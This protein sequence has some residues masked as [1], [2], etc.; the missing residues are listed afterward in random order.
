MIAYPQRISDI[1]PE[2]EK[3]ILKKDKTIKPF[4][5]RS[6]W[7]KKR[8]YTLLLVENY[9]EV[10]LIL[11]RIISTLTRLGAIQDKISSSPTTGQTLRQVEGEYHYLLNVSLPV[12][13]KCLYLWT[14]Q[15]TN[16]FIKSGVGIDLA[17]L[18]RISL[19]RH[20]FITHIHENV[21]F[22]KSLLT[23]GGSIFRTESEHVAILFHPF[24]YSK[25]KFT[26][27]KAVVKKAT[28]YIP[29]L[30]TENNTWKQHYIL[31]RHLNKITDPELKENVKK[32]II[33]SGIATEPPALIANALLAALKKYQ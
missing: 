24:L 29:E 22:K 31:Y 27:M 7:T 14:A 2:L 5:T 4:R 8:A 17:E 25:N 21:F 18:K 33:K 6:R 12:D 1:V 16:I 32:F 23:R 13:V 11:K 19:V 9:K 30:A 3:E 28:P 10:V 15:I 20:K 26:G